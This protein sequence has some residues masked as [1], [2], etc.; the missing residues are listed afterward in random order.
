MTTAFEMQN[1]SKLDEPAH[2]Q[3][4]ARIRIPSDRNSITEYAIRSFFATWYGAP[5]HFRASNSSPYICYF[6]TVPREYSSSPA[7]SQLRSAVLSVSLA[8]L[9]AT[10][11]IPEAGMLAERQYTETLS[12]INEALNTPASALCDETL[13][14]IEIL[15]LAEYTR[16]HSSIQSLPWW[17]HVQGAAEIVKQRGP[18][19]LNTKLGVSLFL[20]A[21]IKMV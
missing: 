12:A 7:K 1:D 5:T 16:K 20:S 18:S 2:L 8:Q 21:K 14:A 6:S 19:Q 11:S 17:Q 10:T 13:M 3:P 9:S 15:S 4:L